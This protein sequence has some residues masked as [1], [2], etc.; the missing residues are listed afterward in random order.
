MESFP[1]NAG[2]D[3]YTCVFCKTGSEQSVAYAIMTL[4][5]GLYA[6]PVRQIKHQSIN[7]IK[8]HKEHILLPGYVFISVP[9]DIIGV[10]LYDCGRLP[11]VYRLLKDGEGH[12][13]LQGADE[14]FAHW[15][16]NNKGLIGLSQAYMAGDKVQLLSGPL[17]EREGNIIKIDRRGRNGLIEFMFDG[18]AR[19]VWLAFEFTEIRKL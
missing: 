11:D 19:R 2:A 17:K 15:I 10:N 16:I 8:S 13:E 7:G 3:R 18:R 6:T 9:F 1:D 4:F 5:P 12:W 14:A